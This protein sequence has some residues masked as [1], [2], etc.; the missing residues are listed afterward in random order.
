MKLSI[1]VPFFNEENMI[2]K[3]YDALVAEVNKFTK[4]EFG[5]TGLSPRVL[6]KGNDGSLWIGTNVSG[7]YNYK[8]KKFIH[9]INP[10]T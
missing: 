5:F 8:N 2:Q 6:C 10:K 1:I 7:L 9:Y 3:M 4:A